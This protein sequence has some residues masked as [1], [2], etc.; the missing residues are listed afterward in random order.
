[1]NIKTHH[2]LI[3][4]QGSSYKFYLIYEDDAGRW[5][6]AYG[7]IGKVSSA[8]KEV[9]SSKALELHKQKIKKGYRQPNAN[10]YHIFEQVVDALVADTGHEFNFMTA[11]DEPKPE[12]VVKKKAIVTHIERARM[13]EGFFQL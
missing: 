5:Y 10:E 2:L 6:T 12:P 11:V 1:M 13:N 7:P 4:T 3:Y 8:D 9:S